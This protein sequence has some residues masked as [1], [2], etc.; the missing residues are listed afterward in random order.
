[1]DT[2]P[3]DP[4]SHD[5]YDTIAKNKFIAYLKD[6]GYVDA[7]ENPNKYG[8]DILAT[9]ADGSLHKYD[10]EVKTG[11]KVRYFPWTGLHIPERKRKFAEPINQYFVVMNEELKHAFIVSG[12]TY[13]ECERIIKNTV[14]MPEDTFVEIPVKDCK[15]VELVNS[16]YV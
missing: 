9:H 14:N 3:F 7:V 15:R 1:M 6:N 8:I 13:L 16:L 11:W 12:A 4:K 10:V 2:K 5:K